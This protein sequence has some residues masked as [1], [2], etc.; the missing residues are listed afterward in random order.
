MLMQSPQENLKAQGALVE[1]PNQLDW[2]YSMQH[3][4]Y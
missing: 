1:E 4:K 3:D 2:E